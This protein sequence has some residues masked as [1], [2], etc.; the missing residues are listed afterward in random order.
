MSNAP[1]ETTITDGE[2][3]VVP[4]SFDVEVLHSLNDRI[5]Q[6]LAYVKELSIHCLADDDCNVSNNIPLALQKAKDLK[7]YLFTVVKESKKHG[8]TTVLQHL[9]AQAGKCPHGLDGLD[10]TAGLLSLAEQIGLQRSPERNRQEI[11]TI[12]FCSEKGK[13]YIPNKHGNY[14]KVTKDDVSDLL[15][16]LGMSSAMPIGGGLS[17]VDDKINRIRL[18][19]SVSHVTELGGYKRGFHSF[20]STRILVPNGV[21]PLEP[22]GDPDCLTKCPH[23]VGLIDGLYGELQSCYVVAWLKHAY[24]TLRAGRLDPGQALITVGPPDCGKTLFQKFVVVPL[25]G[26]RHC[27]AYHFMIGKTN[28]NL[29]LARAETWLLD[30]EEPNS[31]H[32]ARRTLAGS[33]KEFCAANI[34]RVHGKGV[35][36]F[37]FPTFKRIVI[38]LNH[39][40]MDCLPEMTTGLLDKTIL[41][42]AEKF[43]M[44]EGCLQ[45]PTAEERAVFAATLSAELPHFAQWLLN[46]E[47]SK[48]FQGRRYG[49]ASYCHPEL[50]SELQDS[51]VNSELWDI[52]QRFLQ[53]QHMDSI[54]ASAA[55]LYGSLLEHDKTGRLRVFCP[56]LSSM[57]A[58]LRDLKNKLDEGDEIAQRCRGMIVHSN[59]RDRG[60]GRKWVINADASYPT[61]RGEASFG[62]FGGEF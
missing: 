46:A 53:D 22:S 32:T 15:V 58:K 33:I 16:S 23:I 50:A 37:T 7:L 60:D 42:Q 21:V 51:G 43:T 59:S 9:T 38:M 49:V 29:D 48:D 1:K 55:T 5:K 34:I 56:S 17:D 11:P 2:V 40:D 62:A 18:S 8:P 19:N 41:A 27:K 14:I 24:E 54:T 39:T 47:V 30:D 52:I 57:A 6:F 25:L 26:G 31:T 44:P 35:D 45:L 61:A 10:F 3:P 13:Y 36:A 28:F 4:P 12:Y 20:G